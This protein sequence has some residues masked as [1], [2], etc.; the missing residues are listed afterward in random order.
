MAYQLFE[1][2]F[3]EIKPMQAR[4]TRVF[5]CPL[6]HMPVNTLVEMKDVKLPNKLVQQVVP[7]PD[8]WTDN[9]TDRPQY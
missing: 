4:G 2:F 1:V 6:S 9:R 5:P 7:P 8:S 3:I